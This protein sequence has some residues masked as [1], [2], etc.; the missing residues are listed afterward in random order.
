MGFIPK[1]AKWYL[2]DLV[3][4]I[5]VEGE[6]RNVVHTNCTLIRADSP[7][8]AH[9][10][11]ITLGKRGNTDY[12]NPEGKTVRIRFRGLKDLNVIHDELDHGAEIS[13]SRDVAVG[14]KIIKSWIRPKRR[15]GVFAPIQ[16]SKGPDYA[17]AEVIEEV[18]ERSPSL[19]GVRGLGYKLSKKQR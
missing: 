1:N 18:Y 11:A 5:R 10:K 19:K 8:E 14:E 2:A 4:E 16:P 3:E 7:E 12:K 17:S 9:K 15:L 13:F 6:R